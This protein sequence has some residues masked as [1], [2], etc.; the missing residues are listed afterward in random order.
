[1]QTPACAADSSRK[2]ARPGPRTWC[3]PAASIIASTGTVASSMYTLALVHN[4]NRPELP[5]SFHRRHID[6]T[7]PGCHAYLAPRFPVKPA[8]CRPPGRR[9]PRGEHEHRDECRAE[10]RG[11]PEVMTAAGGG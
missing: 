2:T 9:D 8:S 7:P 11:Q 1:M 4:S 10:G 6:V 3:C 5:R